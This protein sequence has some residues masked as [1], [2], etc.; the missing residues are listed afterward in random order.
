MHPIPKVRRH[1]KAARNLQ[2]QSQGEVRIQNTA[3][4]RGHVCMGERERVLTVA[5]RERSQD[6]REGQ[7]QVE[8]MTHRPTLPQNEP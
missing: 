3:I 7:T 5:R 1:Q 2:L 6:L 4:N 8:L